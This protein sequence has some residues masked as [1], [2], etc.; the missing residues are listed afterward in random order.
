MSFRLIKVIEF[1]MNKTKK[2]E[3]YNIITYSNM[4]KWKRFSGWGTDRDTHKEKDFHW[5]FHILT[6]EL[7]S[8]LYKLTRRNTWLHYLN[9]RKPL[10]KETNKESTV[11]DHLY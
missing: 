7:Q 4:K 1:C 5:Y 9:A 6:R 10:I 3:N 11:S 8:I 2:K